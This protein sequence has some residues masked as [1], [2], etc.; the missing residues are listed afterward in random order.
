MTNND[1]NT[2][3]VRQLQTESAR[4]LFVFG[5]FNNEELHKFNIEAYHDSHAWYK[6][7]IKEYISKYGGLPSQVGPGRDIKLL[8]GDIR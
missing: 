4:A 8:M 3:S 7:V 1:L 2:L 5:G 6:V